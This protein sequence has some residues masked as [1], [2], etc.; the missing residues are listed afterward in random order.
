MIINTAPASSDLTAVHNYSKT[1][2]RVMIYRERRL[3]LRRGGLIGVYAEGMD[4]LTPIAAR[5]MVPG[6]NRQTPASVAEYM[7]V[8]SG[9]VAAKREEK[10]A[11]MAADIAARDA[12]AAA[13]G[14]S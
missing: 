6:K 7:A 13:L 14:A 4:W 8:V 5:Q 11:K 3:Y 12:R 1:A 9:R 10:A 2:E